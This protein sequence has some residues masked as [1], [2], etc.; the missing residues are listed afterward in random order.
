MDLLETDQGDLTEHLVSQGVLH[1]RTASQNAKLVS[2]VP[3]C[4]VWLLE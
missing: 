3:V 1:K 4:H 2:G